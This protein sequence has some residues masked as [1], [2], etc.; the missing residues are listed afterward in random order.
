MLILYFPVFHIVQKE[1]NNYVVTLNKM[2][3]IV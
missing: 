2:S 3:L 1:M